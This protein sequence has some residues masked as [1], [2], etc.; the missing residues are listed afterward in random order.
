MEDFV[1]RG[2]IIEYREIKADEIPTLSANFDVL[3]VC[4]GKGPLGQLFEHEPAHSPFDRPQ[5]ALCVG[6]FKGIKEPPIRAVTMYF[7]LGV[8]NVRKQPS[9]AQSMIR[10]PP[11]L[12]SRRICA[13]WR[14]IN[15]PTA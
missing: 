7:A 10:P 2:G 3:V 8:S 6:L 9:P 12:A 1:A 11:S 15:S 14:V 5:R 4:T 13:R